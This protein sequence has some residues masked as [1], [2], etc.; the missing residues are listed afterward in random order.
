MK[1]ALLAIVTLVC[2][3]TN[4]DVCFTANR[5]PNEI[6]AAIRDDP[7]ALHDLI[8]DARMRRFPPQCFS[9]EVGTACE[10][11]ER[12]M[13]DAMRRLAVIQ[14]EDAAIQAAALVLDKK[15][16]W[17]GGHALLLAHAVAG[18]GERVVPYLEPHAKESALAEI[19]LQC[20]AQKHPCI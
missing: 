8:V 14:S 19:I 4:Y 5:C 6:P 9:C 10:T 13:I 16:A 18:M 1:K 15:L 11:C 7:R 17:D 20:I 3:C 12:L 2:A